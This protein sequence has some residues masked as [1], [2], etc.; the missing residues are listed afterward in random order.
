MLMIFLLTLFP[1]SHSKF[2]QVHDIN[3]NSAVLTLNTGTG[4]ILEGYNRLLHTIDLE[5]IEQKVAGSEGLVIKINSTTS[6][7][8]N[9]INFKL[10]ELNKNFKS[11]LSLLPSSVKSKRAIETIGSAI[12]FLTGNLDANDLRQIDT[13][14]NLIKRPIVV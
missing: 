13:D 12:E 9:L 11:L 5:Q 3:N 7:L 6:E 2:I 14:L 10:I 8:S 4:K 1:Y